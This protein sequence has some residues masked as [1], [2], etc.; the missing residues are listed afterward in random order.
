MPIT[1]IFI[2]NSSDK[3]NI[4]RELLYIF[5]DFFSKQLPVFTSLQKKEIE[6]MFL[7]DTRHHAGALFYYFVPR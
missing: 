3:E 1:A 7:N 5:Q 2:C 4:F 6:T